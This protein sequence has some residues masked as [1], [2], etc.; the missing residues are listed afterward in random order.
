M[1]LLS[2]TVDYLSRALRPSSNSTGGE[3]Y[4]V[5]PLFFVVCGG[6]F[7]RRLWNSGHAPHDPLRHL[8]DLYQVTLS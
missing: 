1:Y 2:C 8:V 6:F 7:I 3:E 5:V 4:V